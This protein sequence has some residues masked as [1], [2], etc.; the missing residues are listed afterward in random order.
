MQMSA[1]AA[2]FRFCLMSRGLCFPTG[3]QI[4]SHL[5]SYIS[6]FPLFPFVFISL[7]SP[8][9]RS[10]A[11]VFEFSMAKLFIWPCS[12]VLPSW[13]SHM[14]LLLW[15][16]GPKGKVDS[17]SNCILPTTAGF[18]LPS[19]VCE[20]VLYLLLTTLEPYQDIKGCKV[21]EDDE[22]LP[23]AEVLVVITSGLALEEE[24]EGLSGCGDSKL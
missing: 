11:L 10:P 8:F 13:V 17:L 20:S 22:W 5:S 16:T 12:T 14:R 24:H 23:G 1:A 7:L 21:V 18:R 6:P 2:I 15:F 9:Q 3:L 4:Y 19:C